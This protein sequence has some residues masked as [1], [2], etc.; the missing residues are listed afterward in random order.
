MEI[1]ERFLI[2]DD[3]PANNILCIS[4][5]KKTFAEAEVKAFTEPEEGINY[6]E[7]TYRENP[8]PTILFLDL[9]MPTLTGWDV[10]N[11]FQNM[12]SSLN[13]IKVFILSSSINPADKQRAFENGLVEGFL[14]K[15]LSKSALLTLFE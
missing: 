5:I 8:V 4:S 2:I 15:P 3:D 7:H 14:E 13:S 11:R 10:L 9:N 12:I 1:P 6:I